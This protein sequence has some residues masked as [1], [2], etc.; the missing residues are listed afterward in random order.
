MFI[1]LRSPDGRF[2]LKINVAPGLRHLGV[3]EKEQFRH[4]YIVAL[5]THY[6]KKGSKKGFRPFALFL[7]PF[8]RSSAENFRT[9]SLCPGCVI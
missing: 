9:K 5:P 6:I 4:K 8:P 1:R 7:S 2:P 3:T